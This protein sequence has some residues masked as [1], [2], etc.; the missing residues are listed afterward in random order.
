MVYDW[1]MGPIDHPQQ[2]GFMF[3][4]WKK[5][6]VE[7]VAELVDAKSVPSCFCCIRRLGSQTLRFI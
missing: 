2:L 7:D 3:E 6:R 5:V 4:S 1:E